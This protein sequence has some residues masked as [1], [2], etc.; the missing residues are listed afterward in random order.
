M[1][2]RYIDIRTRAYKYKCASLFC[3]DSIDIPAIRTTNWNCNRDEGF[4]PSQLYF[5]ICAFKFAFT[6]SSWVL[7][8]RNYSFRIIDDLVTLKLIDFSMKNNGYFFEEGEKKNEHSTCCT[9]TLPPSPFIFYSI[10]KKIII[11]AN[12]ACLNA[13]RVEKKYFDDSIP[14]YQ[15]LKSN[16]TVQST[17]VSQSFDDTILFFIRGDHSRLSVKFRYDEGSS[18]F[19]VTSTSKQFVPPMIPSLFFARLT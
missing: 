11:H 5:D 4:N 2:H 12:L 1:V 10:K 18:I 16:G 8:E 17:F 9:S 15:L 13:C 19:S 6:G 7:T 14:S 3:D